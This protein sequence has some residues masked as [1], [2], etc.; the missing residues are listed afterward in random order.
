MKKMNREY[1][2]NLLEELRQSVFNLIGDYHDVFSKE[3]MALIINEVVL[4]AFR[5][6]Y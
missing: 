6:F 4:I 1:I 3:E 2:D 5:E